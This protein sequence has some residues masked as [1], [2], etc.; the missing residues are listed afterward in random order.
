LR[1]ELTGIEPLS[2]ADAERLERVF[3]AGEN[4]SGEDGCW[5]F[6][7]LMRDSNRLP[8]QERERFLRFMAAE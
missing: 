3:E 4:A 1:A 5:A 6:K 8:A 2:E 7:V